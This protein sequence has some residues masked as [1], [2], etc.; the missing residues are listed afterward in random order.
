VP[1]IVAELIERQYAGQ[2]VS[3]RRRPQ[4][5]VIVSRTGSVDTA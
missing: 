4:V 3:K 2:F 1:G 5:D